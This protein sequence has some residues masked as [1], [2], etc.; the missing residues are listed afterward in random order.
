M[1]KLILTSF[2]IAAIAGVF[3]FTDIAAAVPGIAQIIFWTFLVL[4]AI[5]TVGWLWRRQRASS[6]LSPLL[7]TAKTSSS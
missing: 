6:R 3:A 1:L 2:L 7:D 4:S 5:G